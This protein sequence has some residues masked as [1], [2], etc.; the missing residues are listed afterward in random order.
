[1]IFRFLI[2]LFIILLFALYLRYTNNITN[3]NIAKYKNKIINQNESLPVEYAFGGKSKDLPS[4]YIKKIVNAYCRT[5]NKDH[6]IFLFE[7]EMLGET[8]YYI[9]FLFFYIIFLIM[10]LI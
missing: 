6:L 4:E 8:G 2:I 1:M 5:K 3:E 9:I 7:S 10:I